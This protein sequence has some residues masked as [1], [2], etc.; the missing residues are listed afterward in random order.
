MR[1]HLTKMHKP[2][3]TSDEAA[4]VIASTTG[5]GTPTPSAIDVIIQ[6]PSTTSFIGKST[7]N[8]IGSIDVC[9]RAP[10]PRAQQQTDGQWVCLCGFKAVGLRGLR[11]HERGCGTLK[12]L[13]PVSQSSAPVESARPCHPAPNNVALRTA[14]HLIKCNSDNHSC[15]SVTTQTDNIES[16]GND[17]IMI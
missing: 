12:L 6:S 16:N 7:I 11:A 8:P 5:T 10:R 17:I 1:I 9:T 4:T 14:D 13:R 2:A 15:T 3:A